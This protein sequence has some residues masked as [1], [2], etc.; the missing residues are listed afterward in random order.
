MLR[1]LIMAGE[2]AP[3]EHL[4]EVPLATRP[5]TSRTPV[6]G[7][8]MT[9]AQE[10]LLTYKPQRGYAV[11]EVS[12]R[13]VVDAYRVR[14]HLEGLACRELAGKGLPAEAEAVLLRCL[15]DGD[16]ILRIGRLREEDNETWRSMNDRLHMTILNA[17]D[18]ECLIDVTQRTLTLPLLSSR[19][20]HWHDYEALKMSHHF[21]HIIVRAIQRRESERAEAAMREH[22][23]ASIEVIERHFQAAGTSHQPTTGNPAPLYT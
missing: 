6:R 2:I 21:H 23:W 1:Q 10:G 15:E 22:I 14:A 20:V 17:T 8:L 5:R 11:R 7:A 3:G 18:N 9:P 12:L 4:L 19:V 16:D 13:R